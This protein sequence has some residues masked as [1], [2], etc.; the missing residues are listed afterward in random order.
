MTHILLTDIRPVLEYVSVVWNTGCNEDVRRLKAVHI[1]WTRH[2]KDLGNKEYGVR[3]R[4][5]NLYS[6]KGRFLRADLKVLGSLSR[7][8]PYSTVR[9]LGLDIRSSYP[10]QQVHNQGSPMST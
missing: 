9:L 8:Q 3:L 2:I 10:R 6:V 7:T 5:L 4:A 1:L